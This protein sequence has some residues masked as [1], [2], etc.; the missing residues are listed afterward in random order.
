MAKHAAQ[1]AHVAPASRRLSDE[2]VTK[3]GAMRIKLNAGWTLVGG[4]ILLLV[5]AGKLDLL[6]VL[7]PSA[8]VV[9]YAIARLPDDKTNATG[10]LR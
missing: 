9:A 2:T 6:V 5:F 3:R 1:T 7:I 10:G 4:A 8:A